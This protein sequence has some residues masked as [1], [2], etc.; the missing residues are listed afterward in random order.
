ML[1]RGGIILG[2]DDQKIARNIIDGRMTVFDQFMANVQF[3]VN[4]SVGRPKKTYPPV[5]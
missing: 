1:P 2:R 4:R 3:A 5:I